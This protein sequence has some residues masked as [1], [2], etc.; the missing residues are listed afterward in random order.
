MAADAEEIDRLAR[1]GSAAHALAG[2]L[3][4][5]AA[6]LVG[7]PSEARARLHDGVAAAGRA[8]L[9]TM[10]SLCLAYLAYLAG[11]DEDWQ[12]MGQLVIRA[13]DLMEVARAEDFVTMAPVHAT[14]SLALAHEHRVQEAERAATS[15]LRL[16]SAVAPIAPW[17]DVHTRA[18]LA[19]TRLLL[20][21]PAAA[22]MLLA[23][24]QQVVDLVPDAPE[25]RSQLDRVWEMV[26]HKPLSTRVGPSSITP[27]ELRVLRLLPTHLSFADIS[28]Q[29]FLTRNTVKT[30]AIST[31]RKLGVTSRGEAVAQARLLGLIPAGQNGN[32]G[33]GP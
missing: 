8:A 11:L 33:P 10:Q 24:A 16:L 1:P 13:R 18:V 22:R 2:F 30:Q 19:R 14:V 31:Y 6:D 29:L 27:A 21:D 12:D 20:G 23:E 7:G 25:L 3:G 5:V 9:P 15:A 28:D 17:L 4:G 26:Q 32:P